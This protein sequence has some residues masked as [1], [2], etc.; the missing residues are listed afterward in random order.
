MGREL[1]NPLPSGLCHWYLIEGRTKEP[2]KYSSPMELG[3]FHTQY[4]KKGTGR[5]SAITHDK[6][7][8]SPKYINGPKENVQLIDSKNRGMDYYFN[9]FLTVIP[10]NCSPGEKSQGNIGTEGRHSTGTARLFEIFCRWHNRCFKYQLPKN[11][12]WEESPLLSP[13]PGKKIL[14]KRIRP[15]QSPDMGNWFFPGQISA[16]TNIKTQKP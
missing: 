13:V 11:K 8:S 1:N 9:T 10:G 4:L 6:L 14:Q 12:D 15:T 5:L 2:G 16:I 3:K 7:L